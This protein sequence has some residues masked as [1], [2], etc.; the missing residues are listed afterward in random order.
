M[1]FLV[2]GEFGLLGTHANL[3]HWQALTHRRAHA[4]HDIAKNHVAQCW[5]HA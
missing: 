1:L 4:V 3:R 5:L 2:F